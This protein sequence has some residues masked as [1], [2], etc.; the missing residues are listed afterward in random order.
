MTRGTVVI[1]DTAPQWVS[2]LVS[3]TCDWVLNQLRGPFSLTGYPNATPPV[4]FSP[5]RGLAYDDTN[6]VPWFSN[7]AGVWADLAT[8]AQIPSIPA[9]GLASGTWTPTLT[10]TANI[11]SSTALQCQYMRVGNVVSFSG[12]VTLTPTL[13]A[14]LTTLGIS[15]PISSAFSAAQ[16]LG[17]SADS[18]S[19]ASASAAM[20][21]DT[22]NARATVQ[23][24]SVGTG[25]ETFY[26]SGSYLIL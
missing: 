23:M 22:A 25:A 3:N 7:K 24:I 19:V 16:N 4:A 21:A 8:A 15:L 11:T 6:D 26:F 14:T 12:G 20:F 17:G 5:K 10:N 2:S 1:P 18:A 13:L 9:G